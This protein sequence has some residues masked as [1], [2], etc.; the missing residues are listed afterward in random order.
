MGRYPYLPPFRQERE[1]DRSMIR[2]AM[3]ETDVWH[4]GERQFGELSG[5]ERQLVVL[6]SALAQEPQI[7]LL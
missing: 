3:E 5:G 4:L 1:T 2:K 6:A 7:L